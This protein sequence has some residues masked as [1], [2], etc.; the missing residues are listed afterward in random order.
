MQVKPYPGHS[1]AI[2][3]SSLICLCGQQFYC[4]PA[5]DFSSNASPLS[6]SFCNEL[7]IDVTNANYNKIHDMLVLFKLHKTMASESLNKRRY[8]D[9]KKVIE[10]INKHN[11]YYETNSND[12]QKTFTLLNVLV[13][14]LNNDV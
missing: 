13:D 6:K 12:L 10:R 14:Y 8:Y 3:L 2:V 1:L 7:E 4:C 11:S 9:G 5:A